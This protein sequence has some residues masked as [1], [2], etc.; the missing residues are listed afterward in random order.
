MTP[1]SGAS[2]FQPGSKLWIVSDTKSSSWTLRL[3]YYLNFLILKNFRH[4]PPTVSTQLVSILSATGL[5]SELQQTE[6]SLFNSEKPLL[7][8]SENQFPNLW[9]LHL[10]Y[11]GQLSA[12]IKKAHTYWKGLHSPSLRFFLPYQVDP[13]ELENAWQSVSDF[14]D[15][16]VVN[17][18]TTGRET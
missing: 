14:T 18:T 2:A 11:D 13:L 15:I 6:K 12:W 8:Y 3:D 4:A 9:T 10:P 17:D 7:L 16:T 1:L 5:S